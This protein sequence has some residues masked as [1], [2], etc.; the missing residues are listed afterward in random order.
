MKITV[1]VVPNARRNLIRQEADRLKVYLTAPAVD[2]KAN[3]A[4][5]DLL[6]DHYGVRKGRIQ[7]VCG[8]QSRQKIVMIENERAAD[9]PGKN[10]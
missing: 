10:K 9:A 7:I 6:A 1:R 3:K 4:L 5:T 8:H 2:G